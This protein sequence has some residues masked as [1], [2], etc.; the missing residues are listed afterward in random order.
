MSRLTENTRPS[1]V[2]ANGARVSGLLVECVTGFPP[3]NPCNS[4]GVELFV[5]GN[6]QSIYQVYSLTVHRDSW[7]WEDCP[8][9]SR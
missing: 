2:S 3:K 4:H 5:R 7:R 6:L 9:V 1:K 8:H